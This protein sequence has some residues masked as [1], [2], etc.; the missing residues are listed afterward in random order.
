MR[1]KPATKNYNNHLNYVILITCKHHPFFPSPL[2][3]GTGMGCTGSLFIG[4]HEIIS[5]KSSFRRNTSGELCSHSGS[6][7]SRSVWPFISPT[8]LWFPHL[9]NVDNPSLPFHSTLYKI[10]YIS[11]F[12]RYSQQFHE[13]DQIESVPQERNIARKG[14]VSLT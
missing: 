8:G 1:P 3:S 13:I 4:R 9:S 7:T 2:G 12:C 5:C 14:T 6:A 10:L 11:Y